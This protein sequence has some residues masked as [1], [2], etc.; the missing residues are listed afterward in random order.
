M[1]IFQKYTTSYVQHSC[2]RIPTYESESIY[3]T[4]QQRTLAPLEFV[5]QFTWKISALQN[6]V[7]TTLH[8]QN[9]HHNFH[10]SIHYRYNKFHSYSNCN[11]WFNLTYDSMLCY[12]QRDFMCVHSDHPNRIILFD[13][14]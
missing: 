2:A 5:H 6:I 8:T 13:R 7:H 12:L 11:L 9:S 1:K 14:M 10:M 3:K 4:V